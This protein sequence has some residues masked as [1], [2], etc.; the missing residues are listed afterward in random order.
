LKLFQ[1]AAQEDPLVVS[2]V[3]DNKMIMELNKR[4]ARDPTFQLPEGYQKVTEKE[5]ENKYTIPAYFNI[6]ESKR[7]AVETLDYIMFQALGIHLLEPM[8]EVKETLRARPILKQMTKDKVMSEITTGAN[9]NVIKAINEQPRT[10]QQKRRT[11]ANKSSNS[12]DQTPIAKTK[13]L[14]NKEL[15]KDDVL[16]K[17]SPPPKPKKEVP[18]P[19]KIELGVILKV[20]VAKQSADKRPTALEAAYTIEELLQAVE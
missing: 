2:G 19:P 3:L 13:N 17:P 16:E 18:P 20:E 11:E 14:L 10:I 15:K 5:I 8:A 4:L 9:K 7:V 6:K 12:V 1:A